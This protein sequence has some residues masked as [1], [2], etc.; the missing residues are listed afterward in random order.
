MTRADLERTCQA[1]GHTIGKGLPE[2]VGFT[3]LMFDYGEKGN[4]AYISSAKREDMVHTLREMA[5]FM[6]TEHIT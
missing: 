4:L 6:E 3:L 5:D 2:G 1:L